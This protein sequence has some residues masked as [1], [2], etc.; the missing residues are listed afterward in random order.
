MFL[1]CFVVS[2]CCF[3][4]DVFLSGIVNCR[5]SVNLLCTEEK[6][7]RDIALHLNPRVSQRYVVRNSRLRKAWGTEETA[8]PTAFP[9]QR[10]RPF[11]IDIF[12]ANESFF[13]QVAT[14]YEHLILVIFFIQ[15]WYYLTYLDF[16]L[17]LSW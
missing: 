7:E 13:I 14:I 16:I 6:G 11:K 15:S 4:C 9:L 5:F 17:L 10:G 2:T 1:N 12:V 8:A 3:T